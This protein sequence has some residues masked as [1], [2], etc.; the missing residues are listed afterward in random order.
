[1]TEA[2]VKLESERDLPKLELP[3]F[4]GSPVDWPKFIEQF[5]THVH[6][7]PG[8]ADTRRLDILLS[9]LQGEAKTLVEGLS[10]TGRNYGLALQELKTAFGLPVKVARAFV[11]KLTYG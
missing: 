8:I 3:T 7:R 6:C 10:Y 9:H 4:N 2:I 11:E 1:M 5:F